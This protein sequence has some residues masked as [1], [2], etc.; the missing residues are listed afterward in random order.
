VLISS[1]V[2]RENGRFSHTRCL[3]L[4]I[5]DARGRTAPARK[6]GTF[7]PDGR[8]RPGAD[9]AERAGQE[10]TWF[11]RTWLEFVG[12]RWTRSWVTAGSRTCIP[13]I[14]TSAS[15][16]TTRRSMR[17]V[18]WPWNTACATRRADIAGSGKWSASFRRGRCRVRRLHW[19]VCRHRRSQEDRGRA[20]AQ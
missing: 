3:T 11:N 5:T 1:S 14:A 15:G 18:R 10:R 4:D 6:R 13:T 9:L 19:L 8:R 7:P 16:S 12:A 2:Y 17:G 20:R